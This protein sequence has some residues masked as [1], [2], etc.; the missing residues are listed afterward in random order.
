MDLKAAKSKQTTGRQDNAALNER[1]ADSE[2]SLKYAL[3]LVAGEFASPA[4]PES[5]KP[6]PTTSLYISIVDPGVAATGTWL[7]TKLS[8]VAVTSTDAVKTAAAES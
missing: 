1:K 2:A 3:G 5:E 4:G 6:H 8:V 7:V